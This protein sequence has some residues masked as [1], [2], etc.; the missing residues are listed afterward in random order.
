MGLVPDFI[1]NFT[2]ACH[3]SIIRQPNKKSPEI[4]YD[5]EKKKK[6]LHG[7]PF[8]RNAYLEALSR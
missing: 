8:F 1:S 4:V 7:L 5:E 6:L 2:I 3:K